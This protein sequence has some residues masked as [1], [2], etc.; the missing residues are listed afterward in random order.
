MKRKVFVFRNP[1]SENVKYAL[2]NVLKKLEENRVAITN[3]GNVAR[4]ISR[5]LGD[6]EESTWM[7]WAWNKNNK[8][9]VFYLP[10]NVRIE[11]LSKTKIR[12]IIET[13]SFGNK[14]Y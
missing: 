8:E 12:F 9:T 10:D 7:N 11:R 14:M 3:N 13:G 5:C 4:H 6:K 1:K 2:E